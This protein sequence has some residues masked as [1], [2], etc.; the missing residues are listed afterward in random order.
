MPYDI[1]IILWIQCWD[2]VLSVL[3]CCNPAGFPNGSRSLF[4]LAILY[5][6]G[7]SF[8][9]LCYQLHWQTVINCSCSRLCL[10]PSGP[11]I[12]EKYQNKSLWCMNC[13]CFPMLSD[14]RYLKW[15]TMNS[16][17]TPSTLGALC[18]AKLPITWVNIHPSKGLL[19]DGK[20]LPELKLTYR[21]RGPLAFN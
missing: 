20:K 3:I 9:F 18:V 1:I 14:I 2:E 7:Q 4:I 6:Q 8:V 19:P 15:S 16:N 10:T 11:Q 21:Q 13:F 12:V 5:I 17:E